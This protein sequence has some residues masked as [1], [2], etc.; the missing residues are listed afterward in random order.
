[1]TRTEEIEKMMKRKTGATV[2]QICEKTG[3]LA[4][5][6]RAFISRMDADITKTK[7]GG[8]PTVYTIVEKAA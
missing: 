4:H 1:M 2:A 8:K 7:N 3:M 6:A 5:S